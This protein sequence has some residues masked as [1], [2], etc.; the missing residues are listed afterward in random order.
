LEALY[1]KPN[2]SKRHPEH[3]IYLTASRPEHRARQ[4]RLVHRYLVHPDASRIS[5]RRHG[6]GDAAH[7][8]MAPFKSADTREFF[9]EGLEQAIARYAIP[10]IFNAD[11]GS[12]FTDKDFTNVLKEHGI[13][14]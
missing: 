7:S 13:E 1:R 12:Q 4:S 9:V 11:Q 6:L 3:K 14:N 5:L 2:L 10:E 8:R